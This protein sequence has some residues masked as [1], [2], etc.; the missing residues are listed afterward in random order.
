MDEIKS[1]RE[2]AAEKL[3]ALEEPTEAER[4]GWKYG[5]EG[6]KLAN[7]YLSEDVNLTVILNEY[8]DKAQPYVT[9]SLAGVLVRNINLPQNEA[10][11]KTS[12]RAMDGLKLVKR[13]QVAVENLLSRLRQL[14]EH[15]A[16][17]GEQQRHQVYEALKAEFEG[18]LRQAMQ[19][20]LGELGN[21]PIDVEKQPQFQAEWRR[22]LGQLESQYQTLLNEIKNELNRLE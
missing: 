17:T 14:F 19:Q 15:Y 1:A 12:K 11:R 21:Y 8:D 22:Q 13:D 5:P 20:Q 16:T 9:R 18:K 3:A 4:L 6:E 7:R 2:I 10:A